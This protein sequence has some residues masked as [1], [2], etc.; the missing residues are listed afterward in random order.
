MKKTTVGAIV[1]RLQDRYHVETDIYKAGDDCAQALLDLKRT[2]KVRKIALATIQEYVVKLPA[3]HEIMAVLDPNS[4]DLSTRGIAF[5]GAGVHPWIISED[6]YMGTTTNYLS[7]EDIQVIGKMRGP[8]MSYDADLPY[9]RFNE[10]GRDVIIIYNGLAMEPNGLPSIP[11][12]CYDYCVHYLLREEY[13]QR[14][15]MR[16]ATLGELAEVEKWTKASARRVAK[17]PTSKNVHNEIFDVLTSFDRK[18]FG[19][20]I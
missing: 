5:P 15:V 2:P 20:A 16:Q 11:E 7:V 3:C 12:E 9:L 19:F 8:Y 4:P 1:N 13:R 17:I 18:S 6:E 14:F 10:N